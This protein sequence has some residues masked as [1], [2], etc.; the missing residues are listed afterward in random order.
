VHPEAAWAYFVLGPLMWIAFF[1]V[2]IVLVVLAI[3][4][5]GGGTFMPPGKMPLNILQERFARGEID[6]EEF[7]ERRR[8]LGE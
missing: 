1:G 3:R 2:V 4:R 6:T 8:V 7:E 5:F